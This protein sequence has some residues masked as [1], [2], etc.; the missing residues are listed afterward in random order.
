MERDKIRK[1]L[2]LNISYVEKNSYVNLAFI[3]TQ[4]DN[5]TKLIGNAD[6]YREIS[7]LVFQ[8]IDVNKDGL[9][10]DKD[11]ALVKELLRGG[12]T[13]KIIQLAIPVLDGALGL[14]AKYDKHTFKFDYN[15]LE[16]IVFGTIIYTMF[17]Y[18]PDVAK[19]HYQLIDIL[20]NMYISIKSMNET[21]ALIDHIN[22][23]FKRKGWCCYRKSRDQCCDDL[24]RH[25][26]KIVAN[27]R[28]RSSSLKDQQSMNRKIKAWE[29]KISRRNN[30]AMYEHINESLGGTI[31]SE[32]ME[33]MD[34]EIVLETAEL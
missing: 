12:D 16:D 1:I 34:E 19:Q 11:I 10:D 8:I 5:I 17:Q 24:D 3:R 7:N 23:F 13:V 27:I 9:F 20:I 28:V 29:K 2:E 15:V 18:V 31:K 30:E 25:L 14:I 33:M 21:K 4:I 22:N 32:M 6:F 26:E